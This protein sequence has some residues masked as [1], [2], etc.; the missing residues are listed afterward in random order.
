MNTYGTV[1]FEALQNLLT[2]PK[3]EKQ[4]KQQQVNCTKIP[5]ADP[6]DIWAVDEVVDE[7]Y[8][9]AAY[10]RRLTPE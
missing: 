1:D 9:I 10:D 2:Q 3:Q 7:Q 8:A 6:N 4:Q 5:K